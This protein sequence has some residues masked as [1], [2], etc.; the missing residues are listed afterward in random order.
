MA[1]TREQKKRRNVV[2]LGSTGSIGRSTLEVIESF[3]DRFS[4]VGL[5]AKS[6]VET[7][8]SQALKHRP[9]FICMSDPAAAEFLR[10]EQL[11]DGAE[12]LAGDEGITRLAS[13]PEVD[14]VVNAMVG[15]AGLL[16]SLAA[17]ESG[18]TLALANKESLVIG[19]PLFEQAAKRTG[20]RILPIDSEHSAIWQC[21]AAGRDVEVR[22]IILT[23][24]GGPFRTLSRGDF[25]KITPE[26]ALNHPTWKMGPKVTVD[27]ATLMN[28]GLEL[29]EAVWLF[30]LPPE[31]ISIVVHPQSIVHSMVEYIDSSVVAQMSAPDMKLPISYALFWP[32]RTQSEFGRLDLT[33]IQS[34]TFLTPD[35]ERF[36]ALNLAYNAA[37]L[38]GTAPAA[39][40]AAN[41]VAVEAF[42][43]G[44]ISFPR[45]TD[46]IEGTLARHRVIPKPTLLDILDADRGARATAA[47]FIS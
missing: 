38:G 34:L 42:L 18:K 26:E 41:E 33:K 31:M 45:I 8:M 36:P 44:R 9:R 32:E 43:L 6:D 46:I 12:V 47:Q 19:G 40:N 1:R 29:I 10:G 14:L 35:A 3:A 13:L 23:A 4:V 5:A 7:I 17:V 2:I 30:S 22:R 11:P 16:A 21:L 27:S 15:A 37:T 24:S 25:E 28:K 39:L 20:A